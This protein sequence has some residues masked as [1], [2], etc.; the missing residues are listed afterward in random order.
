M[1][2][3]SWAKKGRNN[4][5]SPVYCAKGNKTFCPARFLLSRYLEIAYESLPFPIVTN[6]ELGKACIKPEHKEPYIPRPRL[7]TVDLV[8]EELEKISPKNKQ[9]ESGKLT[10]VDDIFDFLTNEVEK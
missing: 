10:D 5:R 9:T 1:W 6:C 4:Q 2:L 8:L 3:G 7:R